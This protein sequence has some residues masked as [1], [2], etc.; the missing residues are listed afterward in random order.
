MVVPE[1]YKRHC[2]RCYVHLFPGEKVSRYY[3][4]KEQHFVDYIK[5][6]GV[7][8]GDAGITFD[9]RLQGGCSGRKLDI[10]VDLYT[11]TVHCE[12]DEDQH[13][14]YTCEN[15]RTMELFQ[16]AGNR[17]QVQLRFNPDGFKSAQ[18]RKY[19]SCFKYNKLGVPVIR[20]QAIPLYRATI[21]EFVGS[22]LFLFTV[23]TTAVNYP[24]AQA[25]GGAN[26]LAPIGVATVFGVTIS[27]LAY[28][29]GDVSGAHLNPAVTLG[30]LVRKTIEP[31]RA[32]L[33]AGMC[34]V[35]RGEKEIDEWYDR[36]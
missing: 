2:L 25:L 3:K 33:I 18:G 20:D 7:F 15:K 35:Y 26:L 36:D 34:R 9:R 27:T 22:G 8:P 24:A 31:T 4:V 1:R 21:A 6:A 19:P 30:F 29:F 10:F 13:H 23:I 14:N 28:T 16:D 12:N 5:A 17:P 32:A 11:H